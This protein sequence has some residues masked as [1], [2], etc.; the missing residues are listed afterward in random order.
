MKPFRAFFIVIG[1]CLC[2]LISFSLYS[3]SSSGSSSNAT[4]TLTFS[5]TQSWDTEIFSK[6]EYKQTLVPDFDTIVIP[7][8]PSNDSAETVQE[9]AL[10]HE[11]KKERVHAQVEIEREMRLEN[12]F[13]GSSTYHELTNPNLRP[14]T[15]HLL[16]TIHTEFLPV[17]VFFKQRFDRVR[18]HYLD[19]TLTPS[20]NVPGHPAYPSGHA[21]QSYL[22][23]LVLSDLDATHSDS[24]ISSALRIAHNREIAGVHYP[25][26]SK[27]GQ[28]LATQYY[29]RLKTTDWYNEQIASARTEWI[30]RN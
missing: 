24:Y 6:L 7:T 11:F 4:S 13:F 5:N 15:A 27:A 22:T 18:P 16:E 12:T 8:P 9:L 17:I 25:S 10:L 1:V 14:N 19:T 2:A 28:A 30:S 23:A 21:A 29:E 20:I 3:S 26:D